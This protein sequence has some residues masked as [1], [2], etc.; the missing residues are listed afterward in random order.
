MNLRTMALAALTGLFMAGPAAALTTPGRAA[1]DTL[2]PFSAPVSLMSDHQEIHERLAGLALEPGAVGVAA[3]ALKELMEPHVV[4]EETYAFPPLALL[5]SLAR[6]ESYQEMRDVLRLT[7]QL[8]A[9]L[10]AMMAEHRAI[11]VAAEDLLVAARDEGRFDAVQLAHQ[12]LRHV[13]VEEGITYP[14]AL[15]VGTLVEFRLGR[16]A[17]YP[18]SR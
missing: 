9:E 4:K 16:T 3:L 8:A 6:G 14:A 17:W 7:D 13:E 10:P 1:G 11:T 5:P 18:D 12:V 15:L 2:S